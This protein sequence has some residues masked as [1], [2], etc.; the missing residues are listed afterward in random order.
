MRPK[1]G[2]GREMDDDRFIDLEVIDLDV[3][4]ERLNPRL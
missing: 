3:I 4:V 2:A 1:Y